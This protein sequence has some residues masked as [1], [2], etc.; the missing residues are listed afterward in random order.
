[1]I[2]DEK[3]DEIENIVEKFTE[4]KVKEEDVKAL[5][6]DPSD[7]ESDYEEDVNLEILEESE[8]ED[9]YEYLEKYFHE[10]KPKRVAFSQARVWIEI[11]KELEWKSGL[12]YTLILLLLVI[13]NG[14]SELERVFSVI[15]Q[16]KSKKRS[17]MKAK[18]LED[19]LMI[20]Y[21]FPDEENYNKEELHALLKEER[22][23]L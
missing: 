16:L 13:P 4:V 3:L 7:I 15:K 18:K 5:E 8:E 11:A 14:T 21:Y 1:M 2:P 23:K 17:R 22:A 20:Y 9:E 6:F 12:L 10:M 19:L